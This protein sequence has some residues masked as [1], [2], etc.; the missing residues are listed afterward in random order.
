MTTKERKI[1][2]VMKA[3]K[4]ITMERKISQKMKAYKRV[5]RE[6]KISQLMKTCKMS[7]RVRKILQ[8]MKTY[9]ARKYVYL[10]LQKTPMTTR[11][12]MTIFH[13]LDLKLLISKLMKKK[14]MNRSP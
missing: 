14:V 4:R 6:K 5:T 7:N 3:Y 2:Q 13:Y 11:V 8:G 10:S 1:P 9:K 12:V